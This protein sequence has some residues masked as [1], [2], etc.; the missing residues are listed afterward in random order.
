M[1]RL[2]SSDVSVPHPTHKLKFMTHDEK[3]KS[4]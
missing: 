4:K 3:A 2:C 1:N